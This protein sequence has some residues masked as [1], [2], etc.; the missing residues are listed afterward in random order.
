MYVYTKT[1]TGNV[2]P[3]ASQV[4]KMESNLSALVSRNFVQMRTAKHG[5]WCADSSLFWR[6]TNFSNKH[7]CNFI[8][9]SIIIDF[10]GD[11]HVKGRT[12]VIQI[13]VNS[14]EICNAIHK[15]GIHFK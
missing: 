9:G 7:V 10:G 11:K 1:M 2:I 12:F 4:Q 14:E 5:H 3:Y 13:Q 8:L 6:S 15:A